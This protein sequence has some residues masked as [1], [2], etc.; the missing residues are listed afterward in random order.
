ML[1]IKY[2]LFNPIYKIQVSKDKALGDVFVR[3]I[4]CLDIRAFDKIFV[5][6]FGFLFALTKIKQ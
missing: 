4:K 1:N 2:F 5:I 3:I 6:L